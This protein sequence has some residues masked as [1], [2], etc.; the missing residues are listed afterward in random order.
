MNTRIVN[1][2]QLVSPDPARTASAGGNLL[3]IRTETELLIRDGRI[4]AVGTADR[5]KRAES[6]IDARGGVL[7]PA[8]VDPHTHF[9]LAT[10]PAVSKSRLTTRLRRALTEGVA[11]VEVKCPS[12]DGLSELSALAHAEGMQLPSIVPTL[13]SPAPLQETTHTEAMSELIGNAIP[14]VRRRRWARFCDVECGAGAYTLEA[15]RTIL[16]AARAAGLHLNLHAQGGVLP[17]LGSV[18]SELGLTAIGH[19]CEYG[20]EDLT[21]WQKADLIPVLLPG[22]RLV[23]GRPLPDIAHLFDAELSVGLGTNAG[24]APIAAGSMWLVIAL[25]VS[26][27]NVSLEQALAMV[28][29]HNAHVLELSAE[30]GTVEPGKRADLVILDIADYRDLLG[31]L[32]DNPVRTVIRGGEVVHQR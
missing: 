19:V 31:G 29:L 17:A 25:A 30:I 26:S 12:L 24:S 11:T 21:T 15:A 32:G 2:G 8:L 18:A 5:S 10:D 7:L 4:A 6:E 20:F 14:T 16:R 28:T 3:E 27:M 13:F 9:E 23:R 1:I 22:E